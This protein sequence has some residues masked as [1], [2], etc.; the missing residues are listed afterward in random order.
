MKALDTLNSMALQAHKK[1]YPSVPDHAVPR[2]KYSDKTANGLTKCIIDFLRLSGW[3]A[4]RIS[5]TGRMIDN[6]RT[7]VDV[8]GRT[9]QIGSTRWVKGSG[10]RGS[11]DISATI[12][13]RSVK[14]E[15]KAGKDRQ[16]P[17]QK[18]YQRMIEASGGIYYIARTFDSFYQWY[19]TNFQ[20]KTNE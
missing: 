14:I 5:T 3:Q 9:K 10:T 13:G 4:E 1:R 18:E 8:L 15:V 12:A 11:A 16:G 2:C 17:A 20:T 7:V 6:R 19:A